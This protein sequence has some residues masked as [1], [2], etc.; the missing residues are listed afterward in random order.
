MRISNPTYNYPKTT[1]NVGKTSQHPSFRSSERIVYD[2]NLVHKYNTNTYFFRNDIKWS[3]FVKF[4]EHKY[5]DA[6]KVNII[7][8]ACSSGEE[9]T[10][11]AIILDKI[12]GH[13]AEKLF[14]IKAFDIDSE[15]INCARTG[16]FKITDDEFEK[17]EDLFPDNKYEKYLHVIRNAKGKASWLR[18]KQNVLS[19]IQYKISDI[20]KD[21]KEIPEENTVL[22]CRNFWPYLTIKESAELSKQIAKRLKSSSLI[23]LGKF[24]TFYGIH[25]LFEREGFKHTKQ[26]NIMEKLPPFQAFVLKMAYKIGLKRI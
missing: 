15:N 17:I 8:Y 14:P 10:S 6:S 4:L 12:L 11:L 2:N 9:P 1:F 19:K 21:Y 22:L 3:D 18:A 5:K 26:F 24:D 23:V 25:K 20:T 16:L 13:R 7:D